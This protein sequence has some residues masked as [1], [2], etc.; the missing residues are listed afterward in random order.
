M[1]LILLQHYKNVFPVFGLLCLLVLVVGISTRSYYF[2]LD[3]DY[4][5]VIPMAEFAIQAVK[6]PSVFLTWN[7]YIG[8]G[9][10]VLGD[11]SSLLF[12]P[13]FM[14]WFL[15]FGSVN[16]LRVIMALT[17]LS[18]GF[19]M[20]MFLSTFTFHTRIVQWGA[21]L[22]GTSGALAAMFASGHIE[23]FPTY[24]LSP[25]VFYLMLKK[26][27]MVS[28]SLLVGLIYATLFFSV[29]FYGIWFFS[30]FWIVFRIYDV[31]VK[32]R[33]IFHVCLEGISIYGM[34]VI[35]SLPKLIPFIRDVLPHFD[36]QLTINPYMG[37]VHAWFLPLSYIIPWQVMFYDR[38]FLQKILGFR[39]NWYEY[40]AFITPISFVPLIAI[41]S[42]LKKPI[43]IYVLLSL[44]LGAFYLSLTYAYSPFYYLFHA[45]PFAR[46]FRVPQRIVVP[47]LV[48]L[49]LLLSICFNELLKRYKT[50]KHVLLFVICFSSLAWTFSMSYQTMKTAFSPNRTIEESVA[51]E[52]RKKDSGSFF[53][54][55]FACCMQ[56]YLLAH[57]IPILN[58]YYGWTPVGAP[59]FKTPNG[60]QND[61]SSFTYMMPTYII[62]DSTEDFSEFGYGVHITNQHI[63]V[64]KTDHP[65]IVPSL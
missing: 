62:A 14:P 56:P 23:K 49:I 47:L 32:K 9:R 59:T 53:V 51:Q 8:L 30:L 48:P 28:R 33:T 58:Y 3:T 37:S 31:I 27:F 42:V 13:W 61:Y 2:R 4:N 18:S 39:F 41:R 55:N 34:F 52:I 12:S 25:I 60:E 63:R 24:A 45:I 54:V 7:P 46:S 44:M 21:L 50:M 10:P 11:P 38:P 20:W 22:Y 19:T 35:V 17:V 64:W 29:D 36:R 1:R 57:S 65:T 6:N 40:Y 15:L 5:V 43:V 26:S 16:G